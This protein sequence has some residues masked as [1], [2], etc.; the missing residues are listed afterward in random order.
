M[1]FVYT[2]PANA[3]PLSSNS[4]YQYFYIVLIGVPFI[5]FISFYIQKN[6]DH[7]LLSYARWSASLNNKSS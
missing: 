6:Y 5:F 3:T 1:A 7:L 4:F 2:K